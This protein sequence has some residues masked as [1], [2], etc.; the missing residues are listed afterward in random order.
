MTG[1]PGVTYGGRR[2]CHEH[3]P[4]V[5]LVCGPPGAG[6]T[7]YVLERLRPGDVIVDVDRLFAALSGL[8]EHNKPEVLLPV[9]LAARDAAVT[10][11]ADAGVGKVWVITCGATPDQR[12]AALCG[13][14]A[15]MTTTLETPAAVCLE[16]IGADPF[17]RTHAAASIERWFSEARA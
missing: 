13:I 15:D 8:P 1:C 6:K 9:V 2:R 3:R 4:L 14:Q 12:R 17:R 7:T 10:A 5:E 11:A 16:R